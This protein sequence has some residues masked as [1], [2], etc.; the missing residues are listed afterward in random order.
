[1][2]RLVCTGFLVLAAWWSLPA[3]ATPP[4]IFSSD[5]RPLCS[6]ERGVVV[7]MTTHFN[8][9]SYYTLDTQWRLVLISPAAGTATYADQGGMVQHSIDVDP[10][11]PEQE[12]PTL[13]WATGGVGFVT[14]LQEWGMD[15][16]ALEDA[17]V[18]WV[19]QRHQLSLTAN[20][21]EG[22]LSIGLGTRK[23]DIPARF[24][25][26][27]RDQE[28]LEPL[29]EGT[30]RLDGLAPWTRGEEPGEQQAGLLLLKDSYA[31]A[32]LDVIDPMERITL[33][34]V[35]DR[36]A[37]VRARAW[38]LNALGL[39]LHR[40]EKFDEATAWFE[41]A[42][43]LDP[44]FETAWF[45]LACVWARRGQPARSAAALE[46]LV[47]VPGMGAKVD[48][49]SDFDPVRTSQELAAVRARLQ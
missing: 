25:D 15:N 49:D 28:N 43:Q 17:R 27:R 23:K 29:P 44:S 48:K 7:S 6:G 9:G 14:T 19:E 5:I 18:V 10:H 8:R 12:K 36:A 34:A 2:R 1:M 37:V 41:R 38:V 16:C 4:D 30:V 11:A 42:T 22:Q 47:D 13:T 33:L 35:M 31:I 32:F 45:N 40:A 46:R 20:R 24:I 39:D 21:E 3:A 26:L